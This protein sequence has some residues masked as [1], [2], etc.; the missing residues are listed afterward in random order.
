MVW[1]RLSDD[2]YASL[3]TYSRA[4]AARSVSETV[5]LVVTNAV[6]GEQPTESFLPEL[7]GLKAAIQK[8]ASTVGDLNQNLLCGAEGPVSNTGRRR[9]I[10]MAAANSD[11]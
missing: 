7:A 5:R 3:M 4:S 1:F 11:L 10:G 9:E 2:E 8:L 6:F